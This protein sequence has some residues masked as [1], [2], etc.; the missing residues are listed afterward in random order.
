MGRGR[1]QGRAQRRQPV[2]GFGLRRVDLIRCEHSPSGTRY[3]AIGVGHRTPI[4]RTV[5]AAAAA[6]LVAAGVPLIT[7]EVG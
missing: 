6:E 4:E 2:G 1:V 3:V 7:R 5:P